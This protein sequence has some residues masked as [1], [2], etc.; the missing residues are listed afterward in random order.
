MNRA[1]RRPARLDGHLQRVDDELLAH[2]GCHRPAD[3]PARVEV[4]HRG[5]IQPA[6][7]GLDLLDIRAHQ[8]RL[9]ASGRKSRPT[10]SPK[11]STPSTG[12]VQP[13]RRRRCA[14]C[15]PA[16]RISRATRFSPTRMPPAAQHRVHPGA[17]VAALAGRVNG[18]EAL[19]QPRVMQ[20]PIR[21][22]SRDPRPVTGLRNAEQLALQGDRQFLGLLGFRDVP[23]DS[24]RVPVSR[25]KKAVACL[26]MSR[27][28]SRRL[29]RLRSS[30]SSSRSAL[31]SPSSRS[32]RST[33]TCLAQ[34]R[35]VCCET[36]RLSATSRI[37]RPGAHQLDRLAAELIGIRRSRLRHASPS[38]PRRLRRKC[39]GLRKTGGIPL[40][41][42][43]G[44]GRIPT[45]SMGAAIRSRR[46]RRTKL[47]RCGTLAS[48]RGCRANTL[49]H[50]SR[51]RR[52][53][54]VAGGGARG[55]PTTG[56]SRPGGGCPVAVK[57]QQVVTRSDESPLA[58]HG[59]PASSL[60]AVDLAVEL[61]LPEHRL[62]R[63]LA[64]SVERVTEFG[65]DQP[66]HP[67]VSTALPA[68]S[69]VSSLAGI[70]WDQQRDPLGGHGVHLIA[71]PVAGVS[72]DHVGRC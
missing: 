44:A 56:R 43:L 64:S 27:S 25:A 39:S 46:A 31:V 12:T 26:R 22:R 6:L 28:C 15:R 32:R 9:G 51:V 33:A 7:A 3:D 72:D 52:A 36:P 69:R 50:W 58:V 19:R 20:R 11:G 30:L 10:R 65:C 48:R 66:P 1:L 71:V 8:T 61:C 14:P 54:A 68:G 18:F 70:G 42:R 62:D 60:E 23:V 59:R 5:Q 4:L 40:R 37:D 16:E 47:W 17:A 49:W 41:M 63:H 38:L 45:M 2:V 55:Q 34:L 29:T 53:V 57:L 35:S 67:R 13:L 24:H 21:W